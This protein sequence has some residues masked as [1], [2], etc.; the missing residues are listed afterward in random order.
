MWP[1]RR[2]HLELDDSDYEQESDSELA[3]PRRRKKARRRS[4]PFIDAKACVDGDTS[5]HKG[6]EDENDDL[7]GLLVADDLEFLL[8][9]YYSLFTF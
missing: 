3:P 8:T 4:N 9:N 5:S 2:P 6:T 7:D 1:P